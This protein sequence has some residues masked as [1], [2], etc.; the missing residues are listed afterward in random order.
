MTLRSLTSRERKLLAVAIIVGVAVVYYTMIADPSIDRW[1]SVTTSIQSA[2]FR[3]KRIKTVVHR[4]ELIEFELNE[5]LDKSTSAAEI[6]EQSAEQWL[7]EIER[8]SKSNLWLRRIRPLDPVRSDAITMQSAEI[9]C[10]GEFADIAKFIE[11]ILQSSAIVRIDVMRI[12]PARN[13]AEDVTC[14]L[15]VTKVAYEFVP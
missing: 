11:R 6:T 3:L 8:A 13:N 12:N 14:H 4:R 9:E 10:E 2:E 1:R 7:R 15:I 5:L